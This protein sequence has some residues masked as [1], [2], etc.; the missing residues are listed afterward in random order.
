VGHGPVPLTH[1]RGTHGIGGYHSDLAKAARPAFECAALGAVRP[2]GNIC[3]D[4]AFG[5]PRAAGTGLG[6]QFGIWF[7][8]DI[9]LLE[10][11][12][13]KLVSVLKVP[14]GNVSDL[15]LLRSYLIFVPG[16]KPTPPLNVLNPGLTKKREISHV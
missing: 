6:Q 13:R 12:E 10:N 8:H 14:E 1:Q 3:R 2:V 5:A 4:H 7:C 11:R 15:I 16:V 9:P